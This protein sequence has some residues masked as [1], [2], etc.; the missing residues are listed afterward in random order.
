M[1]ILFFAM[2]NLHETT[3]SLADV[4]RIAREADADVRTVISHL[5]G[6]TKRSTRVG[7]RIACVAATIT[8]ERNLGTNREVVR[9]P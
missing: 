2:S 4:E 8:A 6:V 1:R 5:T 3:F 9:T 7:K